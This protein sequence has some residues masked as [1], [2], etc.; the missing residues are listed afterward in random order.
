MVKVVKFGGSSL[1]DAGQ[2]RKVCDIILADEDRKITVVSA[3]GKRNDDDIKVT[4]L[5]IECAT[6]VIENNC[7]EKSLNDVYERY[8][9]IGKDLGIEESFCQTIYEDLKERIATYN[10]DDDKFMD[11]M[12]A[13]GEDNTAKIVAEYL[14]SEGVDATYVNPKD[15]GLFLNEEFGNARVLPESFANLKKLREV[16]GRIIF[17]G[18]FGYSKD[19]EVVTFSRGG[20]DIT[21]A[22]LAA[23]V[24]ADLYE[25]FTDVDSV[26]VANPRVIN[27]P[28]AINNL[29]YREMREL[30]YAGF[31]VL[32][33]ET[34]EPVYKKGI[35]VAIK[36]TNNP[37]SDGTIISI[38]REID[39]D[40][41]VAGIAC[42]K[43]FFNI[44]ISKY[45]MNR[46]VGFTRKVLQVLEEEN[47]SYDHMPSGIDDI[48][49]ILRDGEIA[50]EDEER[51]LNKIKEAVG[52]DEVN[53]QRGYAILMLVGEGMM[54]AVGVIERA[55]RALAQ[56]NISI[57]MVNQGSSEVSVMFGI[58]EKDADVALKQVYKVFFE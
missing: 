56:S 37:S 48:S 44:N 1:A 36:N 12:K 7:Y 50:V 29:T 38:E 31:T 42:E 2:I 15:A 8:A 41:P 13:S 28:K 52:A 35:P 45:M 21:G 25:N 5:L 32:H 53:I 46:E 34:L 49:V 6:N 18:F 57:Q 4:D 58:K 47:I 16:S 54:G 23:A 14:K 11:L 19:G 20:S 24:D 17:P 51:I 3:P 40:F 43:G 27:N 55:S 10:G 33:E 22:I 9:L 30:S 39:K 26:F